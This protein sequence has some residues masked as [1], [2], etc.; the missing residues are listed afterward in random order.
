LAFVTRQ[1][2]FGLYSHRVFLQVV[3]DWIIR[4]SHPS[5]SRHK[6]HPCPTCLHA[7]KT[8]VPHGIQY[9]ASYRV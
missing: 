4:N 3:L 8:S 9:E 2:A 6:Y 1:G 5:G 7:T